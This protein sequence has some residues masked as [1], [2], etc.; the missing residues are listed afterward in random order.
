[1]AALDA[2]SY[3]VAAGRYRHVLIVSADIASCGLDWSRLEASGIFG[4]GAAA[5][6]MGPSDDASSAILSSSLQTFSDGAHHCEIKAGGS[7]F[8]QSRV[9][10]AFS[11]LATFQ[12]DG[13]AV[14]RTVGSRL[15]SFVDA[16]LDAAGARMADM[17]VAVPHQASAHA[18]RYTRRRLGIR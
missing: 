6:V 4:D 14:F 18:L 15:P 3:Q 10:E 17:A 1:L 5:V 11:P 8:P 13:K 12:M 9:R 16:V 7:G 2:L